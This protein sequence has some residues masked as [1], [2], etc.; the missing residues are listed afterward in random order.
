MR[1]NISDGEDAPVNESDDIDAVRRRLEE[2]QQHKRGRV[3]W[4]VSRH[5]A[6]L[7]LVALD[8]PGPTREPP[9]K[10]GKT[11]RRK[12]RKRLL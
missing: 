12:R 7:A 3:R 4:S 11:R 8:E 2:I 9:A 1:P 10:S 5:T 6:E